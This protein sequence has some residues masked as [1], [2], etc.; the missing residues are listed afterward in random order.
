MSANENGKYTLNE[1][2]HKENIAPSITL[3]KI[4]TPVVANAVKAGQFV[5]VRTDDYAERVPLT[6]ADK[7]QEEETITLI[8]QVVGTATRKMDSLKVG[9]TFLDVV[10]PL[11]EPTEV[12]EVGTV[13]CIGGGVGVAPVYPITKAFKQAGNRIISVIGARSKEMLILEKEMRAVS[14]ELYIATDDGS[15]GHHGFVTDVLIK[16][17]DDGAEINEVVAIGPGIMMKA[18][19]DI[20]EE[21]DIKT[22]VSLN[23]LMVDGTGM[24]GGCRI[25]V[26]GETKFV[27]VDGPEF[28]GHQVDFNELMQRSEMYVREEHR[29]MWDYECRLQ[30]A[31]DNLK[32]ANKRE[33]MPKQDPKMRVQNFDEV[34]LGYSREQAMRE[35]S[36]CLQCKKAFC[37]AGCPVDIDI[38]AFIAR[39][40]DGDFMGAIH[41]IK[42][43]NSLPAV[44]GRVCPQEEQCE[45]ECILGKKKDP[46]A[47][48]RLERF[49]ADYEFNQGE[50][51]VPKLPKPTGKKVAIIGA[52][53]AGLTVAGELCKKGH[54]VTV[55]EA[56][57]AAGGVLVYG[58]PEFRLPKWIVQRESDYISKL[59]AEIKTSY[60]VGKAKTV[61]QLLEDGYDAVFVG[62][63]A[64]LPYFLNIPG[65]NLNGVYSANEF[66][67]RV[68][69]M[70]AYLF[71]EYNTPIRLGQ[72]I[73]V[74]G[75]GNVAMDSART[76]RR[77]GAEKVYL[78]YRRSREEMPA[79]EE[80]IENAFEEG[81]EPRLLTNPIRILGDEKGWVKGLECVQMELTEPDDSG[82]RRPVPVEGSEHVIDVD[83]VVVA[84]GQGPNPLLTSTTPDLELTKWGNIVADEETGRTSKKGVFA[85]GDIVTGAATVILAMGAGKIAAQSID[86]YLKDGRWDNE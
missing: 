80:E 64:G 85:G 59:G 14:D 76:S 19:A 36:R 7:D 22:I 2:I 43:K 50:V 13:V 16:L 84:I 73:A 17:I 6:V 70:K 15:E 61:D 71:P 79:R 1:I 28:D 44:C 49:V 29:A 34:A 40:K 5:V 33:P 81:I 63:G 35:A 26:G 68:N 78:V 25:T 83:M 45:I 62:T 72:K 74:I 37:V 24:C 10:G 11:G 77:L 31:E 55:F 30:Q 42:E 4:Y 58:I 20:T 12:A 47:I 38:P 60:I 53:P 66:L 56:L 48:G 57:H 54:G 39:I 69:L 75:G 46:V 3:F 32:R 21:K 27:C 41:K 8:V 18:V 23:S 9:D 67:T 82:R 65:E 86:Q 51:R 52:G